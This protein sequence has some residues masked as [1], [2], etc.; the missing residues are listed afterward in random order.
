MPKRKDFLVKIRAKNNQLVERRQRHGLNLKEMARRI[1]INYHL[2]MG[3]ENMKVKPFAVCGGL[4][5][6]AQKIVTFW[7]VDASVLW[8]RLVLAVEKNLVTRR[9]DASKLSF[10]LRGVSNREKLLG[11]GDGNE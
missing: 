6:S 7:G 2:Y 3:Y 5:E 4:K 10:V 8:P 9:V 1:G 11:T